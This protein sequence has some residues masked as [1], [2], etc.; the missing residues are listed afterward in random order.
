M[1]AVE[2]TLGC[3]ACRAISEGEAIG[4]RAYVAG[5]LE[6]EEDPFVVFFCPDCAERE[7]G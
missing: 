1:T 3:Q 2:I 6:G 5:G 7:F 4:W